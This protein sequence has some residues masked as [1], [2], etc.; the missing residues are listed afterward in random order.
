MCLLQHC[1]VETDESGRQRESDSEDEQ[2]KAKI[3]SPPPT[4]HRVSVF[5]GL[6]PAALIVRV[7]V[8]CTA[9]YI[10]V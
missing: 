10:Q 5:P 6:S 2:P 9:I 7:Q 4:S 8:P 1:T 3:C